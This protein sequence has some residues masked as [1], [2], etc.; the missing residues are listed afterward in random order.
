[1]TRWACVAAI[2]CVLATG[3]SDDDPTGPSNQPLV[4]TAILSPANEVPAITNAESSGR[5][6]MQVQ[7][8]VTRD[9]SNVVT[10]GT[11]TFYFQLSGFPA[12]TRTQGA[13]IHTAV[14]GVNGAIVVDTGI[15][16]NSALP[17]TGGILEFRSGPVAVTAATA[18]AII[19]NPSA[20]YF[21]VHSPLN[22][23]GFARGQLTRIQ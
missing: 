9:A 15:T 22:P 13:H 10:G 17:L 6:A 19:A 20:F 4:F 3:C 2:A 7:F 8:D 11:A 18:N 14:A 1:M 16:P 23:G 12:D 5:G 21:N